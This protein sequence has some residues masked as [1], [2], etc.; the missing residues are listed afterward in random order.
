MRFRSLLASSCLAAAALALPVIG[1]ANPWI[2]APREYVSEVRSSFFSANDFHDA[3]GERVPYRFGG[4][5]E[6]RRAVFAA[7]LGWRPGRSFF[8]ELP[9]A[10]VTRTFEGA[11]AYSNRTGFS[12][13]RLGVRQRL[14][15]GAGSAIALEAAWKAPLGYDR[16]VRLTVAQRAYVDALHPGLGPA[17]SANAAR[18]AAPP[19]LGEGQQDLEG[20]LHVGLA[21]PGMRGF[22][23]FAGGYRYRFEEPEDEILAGAA[24]GFWLTERLL[25][26]GHYDGRLALGADEPDADAYTE[27]LAGPRLTVRVD[28]RCDV[29]AGSLHTPAGENVPHKDLVYVGFVLKQTGYDRYQGFVGGTRRP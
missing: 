22:L 12:D 19:R 21:M 28:D 23:Q 5:V 18:Q 27:H 9:L 6:E 7:E 13:L 3:A 24:I 29:I 20:R 2:P 25:L 11:A 8:F 4:W 16:T 14:M 26:S 17:D 15:G 10:S 1:L